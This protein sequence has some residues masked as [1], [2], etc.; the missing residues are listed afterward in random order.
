MERLTKTLHRTV[1]YT[2]GEDKNIIPIEMTPNDI[3]VV[4][5]K[6]AEYEDIGTPD[7]LRKLKGGHD[8]CR[9]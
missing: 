3:R 1:A 9:S 7:E 4:L 5:N 6:L 8:V 2:Q